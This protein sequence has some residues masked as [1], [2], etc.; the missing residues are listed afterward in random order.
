MVL[1]IGPMKAGSC[2][3]VNGRGL[4]LAGSK[5]AS[6][7]PASANGAALFRQREGSF[8]IF[9]EAGVFLTGISALPAGGLTPADIYLFIVVSFTSS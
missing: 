3:A 7:P 4:L 9:V 6:S 5:I 1:S 8:D 2:R